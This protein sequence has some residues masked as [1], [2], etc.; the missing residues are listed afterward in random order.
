M[1]PTYETVASLISETS[2]VP[3][4]SITP[5]S[6]IINDLKVDSLDFLD[7]AFGIDKAFG[8]KLPLETWTQDVNSGRATTDDYFILSKLCA[9]IDSLRAG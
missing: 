3:R 1:Q 8:I 6:H 7:V 5:E 2:G 4:E 9:R